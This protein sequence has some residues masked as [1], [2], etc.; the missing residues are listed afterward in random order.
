MHDAP[1]LLLAGGYGVFGGLLARELLGSTTA[2]LRI[3]GRDAAR[4]AAFCASLGELERAAPAALD[5]RDAGAFAEAAR[6]CFAVLCAAGPFQQLPR[7]LP[8]RAVAAGAH[9]LDLGDTREWVLPL[10][11][12]ADLHAA[13]LAA[14][15]AVVP[16]LSTVPA[17]SGV[18]V[19]WLAPRLPGARR[20]RITLF[21]G[22]RNT[23]GGAAVSSSLQAGFLDLEKVD[24]P[25]GRVAAGRYASPDEALLREELGL[26]AEF[27]LALEWSL[28]Q[29]LM[30]AAAPLHRRLSAAGKRRLARLFAFL[31]AP[32]SR[33]GSNRGCLQAELW[34]AAGRRA[35]ASLTSAGQ[36]M[37]ILPLALT[38]EALLSGELKARGVV[39]PWSWLPPEA[40]IARLAARGLVF[41]ADEIRNGRE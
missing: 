13:S 28:G 26:E 27:R 17:L 14:G 22:N 18:L 33:F 37:A 39:R 23:K 29:R 3:A 35:A 4:A 36:R 21:I 16:G 11:G 9:W 31:A 7:E 40:W 41:Q 24:V 32:T 12:D 30:A 25:F 8:A 10:L 6:G 15:R 34:D 5:L 20:G 2:R 38:V 1:P 19:R